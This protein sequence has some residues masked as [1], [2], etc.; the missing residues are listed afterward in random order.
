MPRPHIA[1]RKIRDALRLRFGEGLSVRQVAASLQV[2]FT[3]VG[4]HLRRAERAGLK[5]P[6]PDDLDDEALEARLFPATA[7]SNEP[8]PRPDWEKIHVELRRP[9]VTLSLLWLEYRETFP[10]GYAYSRFAGGPGRRRRVSPHRRGA[11][12]SGGH[13]PGVAPPF[14]GPSG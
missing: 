5:W 7:P 9:H 1:M 6:L 11:G 3:T 2:P 12:G 4:D 10:D 13:G 14:R 8:R